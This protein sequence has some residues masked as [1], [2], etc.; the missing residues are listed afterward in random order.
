MRLAQ[1]CTTSSMARSLT[2]VA[3]DLLHRIDRH[4]LQQRPHIV[5][6]DLVVIRPCGDVAA[7]ELGDLP[8]DLLAPTLEDTHDRCPPIE[9]EMSLDGTRRG[10][11]QCDDF[12][13]E[14]GQ[15]NYVD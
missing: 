4:A 3:A 5:S 7:H 11:G 12:A 6:Q 13:A 15:V 8:L 1:L 9:P 14:R 10:H 2:D